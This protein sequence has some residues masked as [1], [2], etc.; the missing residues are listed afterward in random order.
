RASFT[1]LL[2]IL[3]YRAMSGAPTVLEMNLPA[4][5]EVRRVEAARVQPLG[6]YPRLAGW[7]TTEDSNNRRLRVEFQSPLTS[8]RQL[9]IE[10][11]P[12][13]PIGPRL[14]LALPSPVDAASAESF[15]A[16]RFEGRRASIR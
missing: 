12:T 7:T 2:G 11:V 8:P 6:S 4:N 1:R 3:Q 10:L 9:F 15:L 14:E 16:F 13:R 5:V